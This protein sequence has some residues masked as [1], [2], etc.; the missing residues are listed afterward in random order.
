MS[1]ASSSA[2]CCTSSASATDTSLPA[3]A[4]PPGP[5]RDGGR[6][7]VCAGLPGDSELVVALGCEPPVT[8]R[9]AKGLAAMPRPPK[10]TPAAPRP[11]KGLRPPRPANGLAMRRAPS[12]ATERT[13]CHAASSCGGRPGG[14]AGAPGLCGGGKG[15]GGK[16]G[17]PLPAP[18]ACSL[19]SESSTLSEP[20]SPGSERSRRCRRIT[21]QPLPAASAASAAA[22]TAMPAT[23]PD[24]RPPPSLLLPLLLA[25]PLPPLAAL[26]LLALLALLALL[27]LLPPLSAKAASSLKY[28]TA[29]VV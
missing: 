3:A 25:A 21:D 16:G 26:L 10:L 6:A 4:K 23:A 19:A 13:G 1:A 22:P 24:E 17:G 27:L 20:V 9:G 11:A 2:R 15:G 8:L 12:H 28:S 7:P 29:F 18:F 14:A 5:C